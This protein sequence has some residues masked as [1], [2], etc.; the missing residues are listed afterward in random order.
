HHEPLGGWAAH[1]L[2]E[3]RHFAG[4]WWLVACYN[5]YQCALAAAGGADQ[6]C[7]ALRLQGEGAIPEYLL[8]KRAKSKALLEVFH[9]EQSARCGNSGHLKSAAAMEWRI[10]R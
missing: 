7:E 2:A 4:I 6:Y 3:Q 9:L 10:C 5:I 1:W 8:P